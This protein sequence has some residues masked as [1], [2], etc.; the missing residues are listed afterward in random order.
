MAKAEQSIK[1]AAEEVKEKEQSA[2]IA[3]GFEGS[4]QKP[5]HASLNIIV[6]AISVTTGK[7]LD[8][9]VKSKRCKGCE[10]Q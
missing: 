8:F 9:E 6:S 7:V 5:G 2:D 3:G 4:W 1:I 10:T